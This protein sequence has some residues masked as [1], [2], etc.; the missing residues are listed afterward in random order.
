MTLVADKNFTIENVFPVVS[1]N[2]RY[3]AFR[4]VIVMF[5]LFT[6][7]VNLILVALSCSKVA[8]ACDYKATEP[9]PLYKRPQ[10]Q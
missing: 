9:H 2:L 7:K 1:Y 4:E 8:T 6:F 10:I 5:S 3:Q